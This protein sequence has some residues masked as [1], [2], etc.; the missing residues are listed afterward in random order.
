M[1]VIFLVARETIRFGILV[2]RTRVAAFASHCDMQAG[3]WKRRQ[4]MVKCHILP[5]GSSLVATLAILAELAQMN[6]LFL[7]AVKASHWQFGREVLAM[8]ISAGGLGMGTRQRKPCQ[9]AMVKGLVLPVFFSV[10]ALAL[11]TKP[12]I[13]HVLHGMAAETGF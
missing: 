9:L 4:C 8:T 11:F 13:M 7:V 6:V 12:R 1:Y 10:A 3:Q 5:P 2:G